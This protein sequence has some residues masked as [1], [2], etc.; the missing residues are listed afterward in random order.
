MLDE[1]LSVAWR[2][3]DLVFAAKGPAETVALLERIE[4]VATRHGDDF[5]RRLARWPKGEFCMAD[6]AWREM[7]S[8]SGDRYLEAWA[9]LLL[10]WTLAEDE[11]TAAAPVLEEARAAATASGMRSLRAMAHLAEAE[12]ACSTG[13]LATAIQLTTDLLHRPWAFW[14]DAVR[15]AS[16]AALLAGDEDDAARG[17][18]RR[19]TRVP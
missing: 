19:R 6:P 13:D 5:Y 9:P 12:L 3:S 7:A 11:P 16:F 10:A 14:G 17:D 8:E 15:L 4:A 18:R 1:W 2:T